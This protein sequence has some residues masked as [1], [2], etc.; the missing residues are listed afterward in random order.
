M[1]KPAN[2]QLL[3]ISLVGLGIVRHHHNVLVG[4]VINRTKLQ[5]THFV[6]KPSQILRAEIG[7]QVLDAGLPTMYRSEV[8]HNAWNS[9]G[10]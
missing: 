5:V 3:T 10:E 6:G 2:P 1:I 8:E 4:G 9:G 7:C